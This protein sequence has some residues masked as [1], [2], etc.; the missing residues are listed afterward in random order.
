M[1]IFLKEDKNVQ[2]QQTT[3]QQPQNQNQGNKNLIDRDITLVKRAKLESR[4]DP[5]YEAQLQKNMELC[6]QKIKTK[7]DKERALKELKI[8]QK[9]TSGTTNPSAIDIA[10]FFLPIPFLAVAKAAYGNSTQRKRQ[11]IRKLNQ[12]IKR[13]EKMEVAD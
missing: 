9:H 5:E 3:Q 2:Q 6:I 13:I 8:I 4:I 7:K 10:L 12:T 1:N 11:F